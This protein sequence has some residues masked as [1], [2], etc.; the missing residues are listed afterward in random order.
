MENDE[1]RLLLS[2]SELLYKKLKALSEDGYRQFHSRLMPKE[3]VVLGVRAPVL[4]SLS[5]RLAACEDTCTL[6]KYCQA[7]DGKSYE[8]ILLRGLVTT[9][10]N[11]SEEKRRA[12][13]SKYLVSLESWA[14]CDF[15]VQSMKCVSNDR[16]GYEKWLN[17]LFN[18]Q[19]P[20]TVRFA[21]VL[22]FWYRLDIN[23][24][25]PKGLLKT[26][27][28][29]TSGADCI[30]SAIAWG[31]SF[32]LSDEAA[33]EETLLLLK[34]TAFAPPVRRLAIQKSI[35]ARRV[36]AHIKSELREMRLLLR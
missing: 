23:G 27:Q 4:H 16:H 12:L 1:I 29:I 3:S 24:E 6:D 18:T 36:P 2:D 25:Y 32:L 17:S 14:S 19:N 28:G 35:E 22:S 8:E 30:T 20:Y 5:K 34:G 10:I 21:V 31:L 7:V 9:R 15:L 11:C 26:Y 13:L 33:A